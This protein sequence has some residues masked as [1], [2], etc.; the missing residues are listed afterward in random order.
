MQKER[1]V[2]H[3]AVPQSAW[4][5]ADWALRQPIPNRLTLEVLDELRFELFHQ[6]RIVTSNPDDGWEDWVNDEIQNIADR[7]K[8]ITLRRPRARRAALRRGIV[9]YV[10]DDV[11]P[12]CEQPLD[13]AE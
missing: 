7:L 4:D 9:D 8:Q 2:A 10:L 13:E 12:H 11:C 5:R 1:K 3:P 6:L